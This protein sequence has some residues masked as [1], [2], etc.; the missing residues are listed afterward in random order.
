MQIKMKRTNRGW[1]AGAWLLGFAALT[2]N[3]T[4]ADSFYWDANPLTEGA[5]NGA[6][7]WN[8]TGSNWLDSAAENAPWLNTVDHEAI[9][10]SGADAA[11]NITVSGPI[12][13]GALTFT[14]D[15]YTFSGGK[16]AFESA[17]NNFGINMKAASPATVTFNN[18]QLNTR[19]VFYFTPNQSIVLNT[20]AALGDNQY[21]LY[22]YGSVYAYVEAMAGV[23]DRA[24][25]GRT[26]TL[27][28]RGGVYISNAVHYNI[29]DAANETAGTVVTSATLASRGWTSVGDNA[30]GLLTV[31]G[32]LLTGNNN[33]FSGINIGNG[34]NGN[35]RLIVSGGT[36][37]TVN[38][39]NTWGQIIVGSAK[40]GELNAR[41]GLVN[42]SGTA[43]VVAGGAGATGILTVSGS[44]E[45]RA[46]GVQFGADNVN[47]T[48]SATAALTVS[49]GLLRLGADGLRLANN[50]TGLTPSILLTGGTVAADADWSSALNMTLGG[51]VTFDGGANT[52]TLSGVLDGAGGL[53]VSG[54]TLLLGGANTYT[55]DV[56]V[57]A[58][59][60]KLDDS[61][62]LGSVGGLF[63]NSGA[64]VDLN[65]DGT[66]VIDRL[67]FNQ[68]T[69]S[70]LNFNQAYTVAELNNLLSVSVFTGNGAL[71][72]IPEPA[73]WTLLLTGTALSLGLIM[74]KRVDEKTPGI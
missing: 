26:A 32:G 7:T 25:V 72:V 1:R 55:G 68:L 27:E 35:G 20:T 30:E 61:G 58:G 4:R 49:G 48:A 15:G 62:A 33:G 50:T 19:R 69:V 13:G 3:I 24:A 71:M 38:G 44:A 64:A 60:L 34:A 36:I 73:T 16:L 10:G 67:L 53:A 70:G 11:G 28:Y 23:P 63:V 59:V 52:I 22:A 2:L 41:G 9:F 66:A 46:R 6:G 21:F 51:G 5:Q 56:T 57:S 14:R 65:Y 8:S 42:S 18:Q 37:T 43:I 29:G 45:V 74:M 12:N 54:G 31:K 47:F 40:R 17:N 39:N